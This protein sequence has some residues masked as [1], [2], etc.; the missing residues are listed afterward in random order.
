VL[1]RLSGRNIND[2]IPTER[3]KLE[4][5]VGLLNRDPVTEIRY[6]QRRAIL[7]L[8]RYPKRPAEV[9]LKERHSRATETSKREAQ[10]FRAALKK[11]VD[12]WLAVRPNSHLWQLNNPK[13][14]RAVERT[15]H[16]M[17]PALH[18]TTN[19]GAVLHWPAYVGIGAKNDAVRLF[20]ELFTSRLLG[21]V[22]KCKREGCDRYYFSGSAGRKTEYCPGGKCARH[23]TAKEANQRRRR[24]ER[25]EILKRITQTIG[26][27]GQHG[28]R[29]DWKP[30]TAQHARVTAKFITQAVNK[31]EL[32][33]PRRP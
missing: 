2:L 18:L 10:K 25:D 33:P 14:S 15:L 19:Q 31:G 26:E 32:L 13:L 28:R 16:R 9:R 6:W 20:V 12:S 17:R 3:Q 24:V 23:Q 5:L 22:G 1:T 11:Y 7:E 27:W 4:T 21:Q 30:W 8:H 29:L